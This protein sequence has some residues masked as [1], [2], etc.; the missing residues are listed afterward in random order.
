MSNSTQVLQTTHLPTTDHYVFVILFVFFTV[1]S[2]LWISPAAKLVVDLVGSRDY[3]GVCATFPFLLILFRFA[4]LYI[5]NTQG[6][7]ATIQRKA[8][9]FDSLISMLT[10]YSLV[11]M[12]VTGGISQSPLT[13]LVALIPLLSGQTIQVHNRKRMLT[14]YLVGVFVIGVISGQEWI[15]PPSVYP[16]NLGWDSAG[17]FDFLI[18]T[19]IAVA[20][21]LFELWV[22]RARRN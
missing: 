11:I 10:Y 4:Y 20:A 5:S 14:V 16:T 22:I 17:K 3:F 13:A 19:F 1:V 18:C 9:V 15:K 8:E 21:T 2:S 6:P 7:V 12:L